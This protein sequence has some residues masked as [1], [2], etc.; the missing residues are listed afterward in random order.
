MERAFSPLALSWRDLRERLIAG[1][2]F[3]VGLAAVKTFTDLDKL[4]LP[5][6]A[7]AAAGVFTAL[8]I[9]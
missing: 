1:W 7:S 6:L 4:L 3:A 5:R 9:G 2:D 8:P